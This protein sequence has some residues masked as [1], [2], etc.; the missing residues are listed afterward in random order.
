MMSCETE[1]T[2]DQLRMKGILEKHD[3]LMKKDKEINALGQQIS[4]LTD[5]IAFSTIEKE[6]ALLSYCLPKKT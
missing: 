5:T 3:L 6:T 4:Q 2:P 1:L